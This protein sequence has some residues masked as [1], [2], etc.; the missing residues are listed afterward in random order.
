MPLGVDFEVSDTMRH[1]HCTLSA[2]FA[3]GDTGSE[4]LLRSHVL[5][6]APPIVMNP[7]SSG[8]EL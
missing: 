1:S 8:T 2:L 3:V 6:V 4:S 7:Y 5:P